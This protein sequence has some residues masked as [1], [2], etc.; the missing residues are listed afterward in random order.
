MTKELDVQKMREEL[1]KIY[2]GFLK[3]PENKKIQHIS[4]KYDE[5]YGGLASYNEILVKKVVPEDIKMALDGLS[6]I[7]QYGSWGPEHAFSNRK[8]IKRATEILQSLKK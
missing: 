8:I 3:N 4:T 5:I 7:Y 6:T 2:E 1:I